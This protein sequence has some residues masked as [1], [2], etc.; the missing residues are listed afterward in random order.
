MT[1]SMQSARQPSKGH[2][3]QISQDH[4]GESTCPRI[5]CGSTD[6][7]DGLSKGPTKQVAQR[8][9]AS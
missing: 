1:W 4:K 9:G 8:V 3:M 6:G 5:G 2:C 7:C